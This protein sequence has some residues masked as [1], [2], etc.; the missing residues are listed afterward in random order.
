[1]HDYF[2]DFIFIIL[3]II[4]EQKLPPT[5]SSRLF[6]LFTS[7]IRVGLKVI[8]SH[9]KIYDNYKVETIIIKKYYK[10]KCFLNNYIVYLSVESIKI[11]QQMFP[12]SIVISD[13]LSNIQIQNLN[14]C[15]LFNKFLLEE[16]YINKIND[17]LNKF[18]IYRSDDGW[19]KSNEQIELKNIYKI[20]PK[21]IIESDKLKD[22]ESYCLLVDQQLLGA[23]WGSVWGLMNDK[24]MNEIEYYLD[25]KYNKINFI[26]ETREVLDISIKLTDKQK[27]TAEFWEG[28][29]GTVTP[30]GYWIMFL[31]CYFKNN[32]KNNFIQ[33]DYF[34][35]LSCALFQVSI[36]VWKIKY[37]YLQ[38]RPIQSIR[39]NFPDKN[40]NYYN[41]NCNGNLW[42]PYQRLASLTPPFCD[43]ISG[44]SSFSSAGA[45]ILNNLLGKDIDKLNIEITTDELIMLSPI[46][47]N[48]QFKVFNLNKI[49][50]N[51]DCSLI[52][53]N[54]PESKITLNFNNW[55]FMAED[56]GISRIYG[57]IHIQSSNLCGLYTGKYISKYILKKIL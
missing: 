12:S 6:Y 21:N 9:I 1:M 43:Y 4:I 49:T 56:A 8:D 29:K 36:S 30:P 52:K 19:K 17:E 3:K 5:F 51:K 44:H 37:K 54:V 48:Y 10:N 31:Y 46:F 45:Y 35:K 2:S 15:S 14:Y 42:L 53:D 20:D 34:Y 16:N 24:K 25:K 55:D 7:L 50:I 23:K 18:Y 38:C 33:A 47:I 26:K 11:I 27:M 28:G 22:K 40:F 57:G 32:K 13:F 39:L 41:G